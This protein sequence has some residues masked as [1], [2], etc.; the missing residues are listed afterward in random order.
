[1]ASIG[2][3]PNWSAGQFSYGASQSPY[4]SPGAYAGP[5]NPA[6]PSNPGA[7]F[8]NA[9]PPLAV[10]ANQSP[11]QSSFDP[12]KPVYQRQLAQPQFAADYSQ[13]LAGTYMPLAQQI[14]Q[15]MTP[16]WNPLQAA[17][18]GQQLND[19]GMANWSQNMQQYAPQF[20]Q[21]GNQAYAGSQAAQQ[22]AYNAA[23]GAAPGMSGMLGARTSLLNQ[24]QKEASGGAPQYLVDFWKQQAGDRM[25]NTMGALG[26]S[27]FGDAQMANQMAANLYQYHTGAEQNLAN[28]I[29][30]W[31]PYMNQVGQNNTSSMVQQAFAPTNYFGQGISGYGSQYGAAANAYQ[32]A[33][34]PLLKRSFFV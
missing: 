15:G 3:L 7:G 25:Q 21:L 24:Q 6:G 9:A 30:N 1:M 8:G 31:N 34:Q 22:E 5:A 11:F 28:T 19:A 2:A 33:E 14:A 12:M 29:N 10:G 23:L 4:S 17:Q 18:Y 26:N 20:Q 32:A 27:R 13:W 16:N